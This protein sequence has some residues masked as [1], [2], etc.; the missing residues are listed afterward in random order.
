[1]SKTVQEMI[2]ELDAFRELKESDYE[3]WDA[4]YWNNGI[5]EPVDL[6]KDVDRESFLYTAEEVS[7]D[8]AGETMVYV[9]SYVED[10]KPKQWY[11]EY[12]NR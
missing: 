6:L 12:D 10:G 5:E 3:A 4:K 11:W 2:P 9:I 1:M 8:P 7:E